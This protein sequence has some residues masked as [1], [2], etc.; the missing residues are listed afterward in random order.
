M[1]YQWKRG[2]VDVGSNAPS[3]TLSSVQPADDGATFRVVVSN[4]EG[5][6]E[7]R[8][9]LLTVRS[10][11]E[12][13]LINHANTD[14]SQIPSAQ[15]LAARQSI[16][17]AYGHTSHGS[18][19]I[20]GMDTLFDADPLYSWNESGTGGALHL[21]DYAMG[22]D[23]GYYP[24]W[25]DNTR[26]YLGTPDG[27]TGRGSG[28]PDINVVMWSWCGQAAERTQQTMID[29]YLAPMNQLE[30][31]YPG[32]TFVYMTGHLNGTGV[33]GNL[34]QRNEQIRAYCLANHKVLFDFADIESYDPSGNGFLALDADDGCN[35]SGGNWASQWVA[36]HSGDPLSQL[37]SACG[38]CAHSQRLNCILKARAAWWLWARLAGWDGT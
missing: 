11:S 31:D 32:V 5:Q 13:I 14:L 9:A 21:D 36:A 24:A 30:A 15:I 20:T 35:Y 10:A 19:L 34:H 23:V 27:V 25:V 18:Q 2:V 6:V 12:T 26:A 16:H 37:A 8:E 29:T 38:E 7:S 17:I 1:S 33:G 22:G 4:A 28:H 3:Y